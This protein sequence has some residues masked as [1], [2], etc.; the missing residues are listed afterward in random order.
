MTAY[1]HCSKEPQTKKSG[2][3][4]PP[5]AL[6]ALCSVLRLTAAESEDLKLL[7]SVE[8]PAIT[9]PFP[10]RLKLHLHNSGQ[11]PVWLY[12]RAM[13]WRPA[14][15]KSGDGSMLEVRLASAGDRETQPTQPGA[16]ATSA[17]GR[18]L[19]SVG[20]PRPKL[21]LL[22]PGEDYEERAVIGLSPAI[23]A[24]ASQKEPLWGPHRLSVI[25]RAQYSN[26]KE[27]ERIVGVRLWQGEVTSNTVEL[28]LHPSDAAAQGSV[29]GKVIGREG[30]PL[31]QGLVSLSDAQERLLDQVLTDFEGRFSFTRLPLGLYWVTV[32][33]PNFTE[34]TA[35]FRHFQLSPAAPAGAIEFVLLP[36]EIHFSKEILHKP[37]LFRVTDGA[38]RP[39]DRVELEITWSSGTV[40]ENVKSRVP[41]DAALALELIPGRQFVTVK[42]R[43]CPKEEHRVDV[44]PGGGIDGFRLMLECA[45]K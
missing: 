17:Q 33:L 35:V 6:L 30:R 39:L 14:A 45:K 27:I 11:E 41:G 25:Y 23:V 9:A 36:R 31:F 37:V 7:I 18:I 19:E 29:A 12:R 8:Q 34:D 40:L 4:Y 24:A 21:V 15:G 5:L 16:S 28:S 26:A 43:G 10:A 2:L 38:G 20:L 3:R 1:N 42:S 13:P 32:R 44:A 22:P